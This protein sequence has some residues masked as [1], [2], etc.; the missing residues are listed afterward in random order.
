MPDEN[1]RASVPDEIQRAWEIMVGLRL[2]VEHTLGKT[3]SRQEEVR[4][5]GTLHAPGHITARCGPLV[6]KINCSDGAE[7]VID[8]AEQSPYHAF[9]GRRVVAT[10]CPC[11]PPLQHVIGVTGHFAI[12]LMQLAEVATD[13]WL[14]EIG[15]GY[16]LTGRFDKV[17]SGAGESLLSF[18]T[19]TGDTFLVANNPAGV[20]IGCTV[21]A[22]CYPVRLS[23]GMAKTQPCLW[24]ICPWS[25]AE[26]W[27]LREGPDAGLPP[28]VYVDADSG[29]VRDRR[30]STEPNEAS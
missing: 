3:L 15:Q 30:G 14:T 8:Y 7:W 4:L 21:Q 18:A 12:S 19:E 6:T 22:L 5:E 27:G 10:G 13:A 29:Q 23:Q 1:N 16:V 24:V 26:L 11:E 25:Y 20:A 2:P 17:M 9:A 28:H